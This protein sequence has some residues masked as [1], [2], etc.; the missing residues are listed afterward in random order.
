MHD[1]LGGHL[2]AGKTYGKLQQRYY[3]KNMAKDT[4]DYC[5]SCEVCARRKDPHRRPGVPLLSPQLDHLSNYGPMQCIAIDTIGPMTSSAGN[6]LALTIVDYYT[7]YGAAIPLRRQTTA[8][9]VVALMDRWFSVHGF[10]K[11]II[12]DNGS[13]FKSKTMREVARL[14][15]IQ[16][17]FVSPYHPQSNGLCERLN[18]TIINMLASY[19]RDKRINGFT[20]Y[21][22]W[23]SHTTQANTLLL[24]LLRISSLMVVKLQLALMPLSLST[25]MSVTYLIMF[26]KCNVISRSL[27]NTSW[28]G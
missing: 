3:W 12:C 10:P 15:G 26:V 27:I 11:L 23:R 20:S 14:L 13:G 7:R 22:W 25:Q 16:I 28:I 1:D 8:N 9:I 6:P 24:V 5:R 17:H 4:F 18:A 19:T 21:K 2:S